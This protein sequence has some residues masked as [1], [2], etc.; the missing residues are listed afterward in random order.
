MDEG[1]EE[2][3]EAGGAA[4]GV[5]DPV[6]SQAD[7]NRFVS[8]WTR[9]VIRTSYV[10]MARR[11][12]EAFLA[13]RFDELLASLFA[14]EFSG[15]PAED[16][17]AEMVRIHFTGTAALE[18]TLRLFATDLPALL[19]VSGPDVKARLIGLIGALAAGY[20]AQLREQT[21]DQQEVIKQAVLQARDAA[22]EALRASEA[23]LRAVF[24]LSA[25]GIA[26]VSLGGVIDEVNAAMRQIFPAAGGDLVGSSMFDLV[27]EE[28]ETELRLFVAELASGESGRFQTE[29]RFSGPDGTHTWVQLSASLVR[30]A[31]GDPDYQVLLYED[32][33]ERHML[34]EQFR[35]QATHDPLTGLANRTLLKTR[36]DTALE[37][38][39]PGR[40]VGLCYFDL[41]GFKTINDSL[42]HPIGDELLRTVAQRLQALTTARGALATRMGGDE[43]VVLVPDTEGAPAL[44]EE[45][46]EMIR[47]ITRPVRIGGHELN[48]LASV[49]VV[50]REVAGTSPDELLRDADITLYRAKADGRAQWVLFDPEQNSMARERF[51]LSA[52]MPAALQQNEM[53]VEYEP[54][55]WLETGKVVAVDARVFWDHEELGELSSSHFLG[56]AEETGM[57][58][59]LGSWM[60]ERVCEHAVRWHER[61]GADT[62]LA[63]VG[64]TRRHFQDPELVRD[65]RQILVNTGLPVEF[66]GL[67]VSEA[68][69]FES[70]GEPV[71][72]VEICR[73]LG[74]RLGVHDFGYDYADVRRLRNVPLSAVKIQGDYLQSFT[75]PSGP[76]PLD[77]H[78]VG[79]LVRTAQLLGVRVVAGGVST[80]LQAKRLQQLGVMAVHGPYTGGLASAME[81]E[82]MLG[83][84]GRL[85]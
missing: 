57:I 50:E 15:R 40:R 76:D 10:P 30:D 25:L 47:E 34:Q 72:T 13:A 61:F 80:E 21:L 16:V 73:D 8:Q 31:Y 84:G 82:A 1:R 49:G 2:R 62:P 43:F 12:V 60:L 6:I 66:L 17:G 65:V 37:A 54:V 58:T 23:R 70:S 42:G 7:R 83:E 36:L 78:L 51:K 46:E 39:S 74:L 41:D 81:I 4:A 75:E 9:E 71:D 3:D 27:D 64:L 44:I 53:F 19:P 18:R 38:S 59:R 63:G 69:L 28:W 85:W 32:I 33:T 45:V 52:A 24:T 48:A 68:A 14:E 56:L 67:S 26:I 79:G 22:E 35:R 55:V 5:P 77:E 29:T 20:S 11:D